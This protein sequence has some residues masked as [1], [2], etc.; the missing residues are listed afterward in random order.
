MAPDLILDRDAN[1]Q[2]QINPE[3]PNAY[4]TKY[5]DEQ[6]YGIRPNVGVIVEF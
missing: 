5:A 6:G 4:L 1:Y 2:P 3:N